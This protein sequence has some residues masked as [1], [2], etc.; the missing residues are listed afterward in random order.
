MHAIDYCIKVGKPTDI[1]LSHNRLCGQ[2]KR[3]L[4][5]NSTDSN[6]RCIATRLP[7]C[8]DWEDHNDQSANSTV[9][10]FRNL[11]GSMTRSHI[12]DQLNPSINPRL[13]Y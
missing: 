3:M 10:Q 5:N 6:Y 4:S 12:P 1:E 13:S 9:P 8:S 11:D 2:L 7:L